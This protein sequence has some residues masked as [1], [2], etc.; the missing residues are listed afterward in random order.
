MTLCMYKFSIFEFY[1]IFEKNLY[2]WKRFPV[3]LPPSLTEK[4][5]TDDDGNVKVCDTFR[6]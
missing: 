5:T 1:Q 3:V 4:Y 6:F 2:Y